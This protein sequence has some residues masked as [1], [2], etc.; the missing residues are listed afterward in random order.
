[1]SSDLN[2]GKKNPSQIPLEGQITQAIFRIK[3]TDFLLNSI[4]D[5]IHR[6]W[7]ETEVP[8]CAARGGTAANR[9]QKIAR[10]RLRRRMSRV[11]FTGQQIRLLTLGF[12]AHKSGHVCGADLV[13]Q[14]NT[15]NFL[16]ITEYFLQLKALS[17]LHSTPYKPN[18]SQKHCMPSKHHT[19]L[20]QSRA[21]LKPAQDWDYSTIFPVGL[22]VT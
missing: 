20:R 2:P 7:Q 21:R 19:C 22:E 1:M 14:Q 15:R 12:T 13:Q 16:R 3:T 6:P 10:E 9:T 18:A 17:F 5:H 8:G 11:A 4:L